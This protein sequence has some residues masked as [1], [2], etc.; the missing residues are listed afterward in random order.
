[1]EMYFFLSR[2]YKRWLQETDGRETI[3]FPRGGMYFISIYC[4]KILFEFMYQCWTSKI[5]A[6]AMTLVPFV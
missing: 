5:E 3:F 4:T 1:M 2:K 6:V